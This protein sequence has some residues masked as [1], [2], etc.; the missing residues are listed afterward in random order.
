MLELRYLHREI[1]LLRDENQQQNNEIAMLKEMVGFQVNSTIPKQIV[2]LIAK[3]I[4]EKKKI[5]SLL[6]C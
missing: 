6:K 4:D 3:E 1:G 2:S 5:K